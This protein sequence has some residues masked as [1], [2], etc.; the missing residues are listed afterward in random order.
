ME[1]GIVLYEA[2]ALDVSKRS[3]RSEPE[4]RFQIFAPYVFIVGK[5][6]EQNRTECL[7]TTFYKRH[8]QT[9]ASLA[10]DRNIQKFDIRVLMFFRPPSHIR[11]FSLTE[12]VGAYVPVIIRI[13][14]LVIQLSSTEL[15]YCP[16]TENGPCKNLMPPVAIA[17][18]SPQIRHCPYSCML[19]MY[20][21]Y[22]VLSAIDVTKRFKFHNYR[23]S[24]QTLYRQ[25]QQDIAPRKTGTAVR[26]PNR[27]R[28]EYRFCGCSPYVQNKTQMQPKSAK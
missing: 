6:D 1:C 15:H 14:G 20:L 3:S 11:L 4:F 25:F 13:N 2:F 16:L 23:Q 26:R 8:V 21:P 27:F 10:R 17:S 18:T 24:Q 9:A 12:R 28:F 22:V 7:F 19:T 5:I